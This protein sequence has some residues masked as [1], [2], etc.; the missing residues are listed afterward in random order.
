[1]PLFA[2]ATAGVT[3]D[4]GTLRRA[5]TSPITLGIVSGLVI[6]KIVGISLFAWVALRFGLA[7]L[8]DGLDRGRS[9]RCRSSPASASRCRSSSRSVAFTRPTISLAKIGILTAS[10]GAGLLGLVAVTLVSRR[11]IGAPEP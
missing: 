4:G 5:F 1:M 10:L 7:R 6:G 3:I 2:L 9:S 11:S 8:P